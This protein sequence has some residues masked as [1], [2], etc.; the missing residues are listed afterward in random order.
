MQSCVTKSRSSSSD[1]DLVPVRL[2][3]PCSPSRARVSTRQVHRRIGEPNKAQRRRP[4]VRA[5][6]DPVL[7]VREAE[8]QSSSTGTLFV[9]AVSN[10]SLLHLTHPRNLVRD[11]ARAPC[12]CSP[13]R[14]NEVKSKTNLEFHQG[15]PRPMLFRWTVSFDIVSRSLS[16]LNVV[17][18]LDAQFFLPHRFSQPPGAVKEIIR[19]H[20]SNSTSKKNK[21]KSDWLL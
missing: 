11:A 2:P 17:F 9:P 13:K 18:C 5:F 6:S 15:T 16:P 14:Q 21:K 20:H 19:K 4:N 12:H 3:T 1:G 7:A 10:P 8:P